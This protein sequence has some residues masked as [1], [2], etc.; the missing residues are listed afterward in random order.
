ML[1]IPLIVMYQFYGG[2]LND[3]AGVSIVA[4]AS[5]GNLGESKFMCHHAYIEHN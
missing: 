3:L 5:F 2:A 4:T 1:A